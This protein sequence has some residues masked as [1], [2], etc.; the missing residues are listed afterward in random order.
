MFLILNR[1][2]ALVMH[3]ASTLSTLCAVH[4]CTIFLCYLGREIEV[5]D[6]H[7]NPNSDYRD[8]VMT[9]IIW[10]ILMLQ[11]Y[12]NI[13]AV[14]YTFDEEGFENSSDLAKDF[15][16][17]LFHKEPRSSKHDCD[18]FLILID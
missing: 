16:Q 18:D 11:T 5:D 3:P 9:E 10:L 12:E 8:Q 2:C 15:I 14:D 4:C 13:V 7:R 6:H 17:R 1:V